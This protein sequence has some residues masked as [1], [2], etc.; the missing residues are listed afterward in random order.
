[1][2]I[3]DWSSDVC[4][5]DLA[6]A[7]AKG[8]ARVDL[9]DGLV[10]EGLVNVIRQMEEIAEIGEKDGRV[11]RIEDRHTRFDAVKPGAGGELALQAVRVARSEEPTSELQS[12]MRNTYAR[13]CCKNKTLH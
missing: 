12:L 4:S 8:I 13:F 2:R 7:H 10:V 1:M 11:V 3:S 6:E 5:S 9:A